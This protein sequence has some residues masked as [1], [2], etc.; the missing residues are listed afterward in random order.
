[1]NFSVTCVVSVTDAYG[2][3]ANA[4]TT[5]EVST[6]P[7]NTTDLTAST[8]TLVSS[9]LSSYNSATLAQTIGSVTGQLNAKNNAV[10]TPCS[11]LNR[12]SC[13]ATANT[14]GSCLSGFIGTLGDSNTQCIAYTA[15]AAT[16]FAH[17]MSSTCLLGQVINGVCVE[18]QK[19]CPN[20]CSSKGA[21]LYYDINN[22]LTTACPVSNAFCKARCSCDTGY[23]GNDCSLSA[24][25]YEGFSSLRASLCH[26]LSQTVAF[27]DVST[28]VVTSR[29]TS[30]VSL[31]A[32]VTQISPSALGNC[33]GVLLDT[34][35]ADPTLVG[36]PTLLSATLN[37]LS[38][39]RFTL[40]NYNE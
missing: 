8:S 32:D 2:G 16:A 28:D 6:S 31:F 34:I 12:E 20:A 17:S 21:C 1:M 30:L 27:E 29:L 9:A 11:S 37:A 10:Q 7:V 4:S 5:V 15:P 39:V 26:A 24:A 3:T 14:C 35:Q 25:E 38:N 40:V 19:P 18:N 23:Y 22:Q 13:S 36:S 33:T